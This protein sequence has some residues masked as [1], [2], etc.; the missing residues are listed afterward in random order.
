[1]C[2]ETLPFSRLFKASDSIRLK[3]Q[4]ANYSNSLSDCEHFFAVNLLKCLARVAKIFNTNTLAII[5]TKQMAFLHE[6]KGYARV[7]ERERELAHVV[8]AFLKNPLYR[9]A[10]SVIQVF[11]FSSCELNFC[12]LQRE[13]RVCMILPLC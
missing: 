3:W 9:Y 8:E 1:M 11:C 4:S 12:D 6:S 2:W 13:P 7:R 5:D 10:L